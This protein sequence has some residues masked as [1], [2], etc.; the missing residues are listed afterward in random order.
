MP[1]P[2]RTCCTA[3]SNASGLSVWSPGRT[4]GR[5]SRGYRPSS[6]RNAISRTVFR[7]G[8]A[9]IPSS[10]P[11]AHRCISE[12]R[13]MFVHVFAAT[14]RLPNNAVVAAQRRTGTALGLRSGNGGSFPRLR[15]GS[16]SVAGRRSRRRRIPVQ[17]N[18]TA[19]VYAAT[20]PHSCGHITPMFARSPWVVRGP[21]HSEREPGRLRRCRSAGAADPGRGSGQAHRNWT[22][23]LGYSR[24]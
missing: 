5:S 18:R 9:S 8:R 11:K 17:R 14:S 20:C 23:R 2:P 13:A 1:A 10:T 6:A 16:L 19:P 3:C 21:V 15:L 7:P 24:H 22:N 4:C 12:R